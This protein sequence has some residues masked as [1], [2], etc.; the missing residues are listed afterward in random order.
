MVPDDAITCNLQHVG[1]SMNLERLERSV[2]RA[3]VDVYHRA[4]RRGLIAGMGGNISARVGNS[5]RILIK[6]TGLSFADVSGSSLV[7]IDLDG[8]PVTGALK[9]SK[10]VPFHTEMYKLRP[11]IR[12]VVHTHSAAATAHAVSGVELPMLTTTARFNLKR[13]PL[14]PFG[15]PGSAD[16]AAKIREAYHD[17]EVNTVL[18]Q[19]HGLISVDEDMYRAYYL[20]ELAEDTARIHLMSK[21]LGPAL[22]F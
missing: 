2:R 13:V 22:A 16:L 19:N 8:S 18:L 15:A 14:V 11:A 9:P 4:Y 17:P 10:E 1:G 20:A 7:L 3:L 21:Q 5:N 12:A 6:A